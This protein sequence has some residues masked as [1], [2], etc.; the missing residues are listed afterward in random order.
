[1]NYFEL[2]QKCENIIA[3][4]PVLTWSPNLWDYIHTLVQCFS[5]CKVRLVH[6][7]K[8][9]VKPETSC[10]YCIH[11]PVVKSLFLFSNFTQ[12]CI[13]QIVSL[14]IHG[15]FF[16]RIQKGIV[17]SQCLP[18]GTFS[19][20]GL[21]FVYFRP[22]LIPIT[23]SMIHIE[24]SIDGVHGIRTRHCRMVGLDETT[25]LWRP[26]SS[27]YLS[28]KGLVMSLQKPRTLSK[29]IYKNVFCFNLKIIGKMQRP[30]SRIE[31]WLF[32]FLQ[33]T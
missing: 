24:T 21:F 9:F 31:D 20:M 10:A 6:S 12:Y 8:Y 26:H 23:I 30:F 1:M 33:S 27:R 7:S 15:I 5:I 14:D 4:M 2:I 28:V 32:L 29:T 13:Y 19:N 18:L 11:S 25:E 3:L 16:D 17:E 22:F